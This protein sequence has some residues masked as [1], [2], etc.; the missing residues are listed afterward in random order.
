MEIDQKRILI[1]RIKI[2][3][4][5]P[6]IFHRILQCT[7]DPKSSASDLKETILKDQSISAKILNLAN[8]AY[9]GYMKKVEDIT[10]AIV[11]LGFDTI[12]DVAVSVSVLK[13]FNDIRIEVFEKEK[14]WMH[15]LAT[16]ETSKLISKYLQEKSLEVYFIIGL[17]HDIGK[18]ILSYF[19]S[20]DYDTVIFDTRVSN[21]YVYE[22]EKKVFGFDLS[23]IHI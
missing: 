17:L 11:I 9:Y 7:E 22:S 18:V 16:A 19:F 5:I 1:Q 3:P 8:S 6:V 14:F 23:L 12:I 10:Q 15:S 4:T 20:E 21:S 13:A 2:L